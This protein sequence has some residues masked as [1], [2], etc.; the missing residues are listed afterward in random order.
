MKKIAAFF[1]MILCYSGLI[2]N[3]QNLVH[4]SQNNFSLIRD[5]FNYDP[6]FRHVVVGSYIDDQGQH[7]GFVKL[8]LGAY[9]STQLFD[10]PDGINT[11]PMCVNSRGAITGTYEDSQ[12]HIHGFICVLGREFTTF[13]VP[14][15][16][17]QEGVDTS[18]VFAFPCCLNSIGDVA[19]YYTDSTGAAHGFIRNEN[20]K[21]TTF[22]CAQSVKK[23][24][25]ASI[26]SAGDITGFYVDT[27]GVTHGFIRDFD[28]SFS[29]FDIPEAGQGS[30]QG[31]SPH[32]IN[33][34]GDIVGNYIDSKGV[35]HGFT[36]T[37][38]SGDLVILDV[39][40]AGTENNQ[41]TYTMC[42]NSAGD[43]AGFYIDDNNIQQCFM[44]KSNSGDMVPL[45]IPG[46]GAVPVSIDLAGRVIGYFIDSEGCSHGF[47]CN[48]GG[49]LYPFT[50][51]HSAGKSRGQ[52]TVPKS[53]SFLG[54]D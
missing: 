50:N 11:I 33:A 12:H 25:P 1:A 38:S 17:P 54:S 34:L 51:I 5:D 47:A 49:K 41:G 35:S 28:G 3:T 44:W 45:D 48:A 4:D 7:H 24:I 36:R 42:M 46:A 21:I 10:V 53:I 9:E 31:T 14:E 2:A 19:G 37:K 29:P 23:I 32:C 40:E 20:G 22:D 15:A 26:N 13:N 18:A 52:G 30:G 43:L 8:F 39:P 6:H 27:E 16:G